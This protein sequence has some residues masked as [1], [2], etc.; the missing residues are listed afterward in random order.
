MFVILLLLGAVL[1]LAITPKL[2]FHFDVT[3]KTIALGII[4]ACLLLR[5]RAIP[6]EI[7]ALWSRRSG[8]ALACLAAMQMLWLGVATARSVDP[9][10]SFFGSNWRQFGIMTIVPM[11]IVA[12][13]VAA[14]LCLRP[15]NI[16]LF[17]RIVAIAGII[18][19]VYGVAQYFDIDP[20]QPAAS[21]R[22][23]AGDSVIVRPPGTLGH[24]DYFAWWLAIEFFC[25]LA[26]ARSSSS[27]W[28]TVGLVCTVCAGTATMLSGTRAALLAVAAGAIALM[29]LSKVI[30]GRKQLFAA[31]LVAGLFFAFFFSPAGTR[32]RARARWSGDEPAGGARPLLWRD[33]LQMAKSRP[34]SGFGPETFQS[35][36]GQWQSEDLARLYPDFHHESPH[37]FALDV[38]TSEGVPGLILALAWI[39]LTF[40]TASRA[41]RTQPARAAPF[42]AALLASLTASMFDAG[43]LGPVL[44]SLLVL[45]MLIAL[46]D[47]EVPSS[48]TVKPWIVVSVCG[49]AA[50]LVA[51]FTIALTVSDF[52]LAA[53]QRA[54]GPAASAAVLRWQLPG[55]AEDIYC[56]RILLNQCQGV[57][58]IAA[59]IECWREAEQ[60]AARAVRSAGDPAN[61]WYNL[62]LFT[63]VQN[64]VRGTEMSLHRAILIAPNWF[65]PHWALARLLSQ[66]GELKRA[67]GEADLAAALNHNHDPEVA[68]TVV[69]LR[70]GSHK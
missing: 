57:T 69:Q 19:S 70:S 41:M 51:V 23:H 28:R 53:F 64:D 5:T 59:R 1:P 63:A 50:A 55:T 47:P 42:A 21:Y 30:I 8:R 15:H 12:V 36:F 4:A 43:V 58:G 29:F 14:H 34:V 17:L 32:L 48:V 65:K 31:C 24:A 61:A 67:R 37:N 25:G 40:K 35:A 16:N 18:A 52:Q 27:I 68:A 45:S 38:L 33:S 39:L 22:A 46:E 9:G 66:T 10:L 60:V 3:P 13:L 62:A 20:F 49:S 44:L 7:A 6:G 54:P 11:L 2:L 26:L 56:S